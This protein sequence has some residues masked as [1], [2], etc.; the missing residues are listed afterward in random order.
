VSPPGVFAQCLDV[1]IRCECRQAIPRARSSGRRRLQSRRERGCRFPKLPWTLPNRVPT[2]M[3]ALGSRSVRRMDQLQCLLNVDQ[4]TSFP[5]AGSSLKCQGITGH[6]LRRPPRDWSD[7]PP[8]SWRACSHPF[9][10]RHNELTTST[11]TSK[12]PARRRPRSSVSLRSA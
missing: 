3:S 6:W 4:L 12:R 2:P 1:E 9:L 7:W 5:T 10:R 8:S 11:H